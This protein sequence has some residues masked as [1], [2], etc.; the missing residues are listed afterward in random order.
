MHDSK[1]CIQFVC[2]NEVCQSIW[3]YDVQ[4]TSLSSRI[5]LAMKHN[6]VGKL[7]ANICKA[8]ICHRAAFVAMGSV[9]PFAAYVT[10]GS[11]TEETGHSQL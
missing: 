10:I 3:S 2:N 5:K 1:N 4:K 7:F 6:V 8:V 9:L 11:D